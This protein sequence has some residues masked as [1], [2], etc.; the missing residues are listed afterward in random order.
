MTIR[1]IYKYVFISVLLCIS[2]SVF[3]EN[4]E[5]AALNK[6]NKFIENAKQFLGVPYVYGGTSKNGIDCSGLIFLAGKGIGLTLPRTASQ[7]CEYS[8]IIEDSEKQ[9]GD[10]L[11]FADNGVKVSHVA[12]YIGDNKMIHAASSGSKTGVIIS[13][14]SE[15]YWKRTYYCAGR[16]IDAVSTSVAQN[17]PTT[18]NTSQQPSS[19]TTTQNQ[20]DDDE[21]RSIPEEGIVIATIKKEDKE[22]RPTNTNTGKKDN[23][24]LK[25]ITLDVS[26]AGGWSLFNTEKFAPVFRG[27]NSK[28]FASYGTDNMKPG[29]G[30][31]FNFD[32]SMDICQLMIMLSFVANDYIRIYAGP[33]ITMGT[34][35]LPGTTE[36]ISA[37]IFPGV[38]GA[39]FQTPTIDIGSFKLQFCQDFSFT[40]F[41]KPDGSALPFGSAAA[42]NFSLQTGIRVTFPHF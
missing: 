10:L 32:P 34:P 39:S 9:A 33:V 7:I 6:R 40:I 22:Q 8:R 11:F 27:V 17:Q 37:S 5:T 2:F 26:V 35:V 36:Q 1:R 21:I 23:P 20:N 16:I 13:E 38:I 3:A 42:A 25:K 4:A 24:F 15:S 14:L 30:L 41:N 29:L 12:I 18:G 28:V 31:A 19:Q